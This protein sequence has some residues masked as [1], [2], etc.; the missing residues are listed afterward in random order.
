MHSK[1]GD[2][3]YRFNIHMLKR[4]MFIVCPIIMSGDDYCGQVWVGKGCK[5]CPIDDFREEVEVRD[6]SIAS[7]V[8]TPIHDII[9]ELVTWECKEH[10]VK[11]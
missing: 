3:N 1:L 5:L 7:K 9:R 2:D 4:V 10:G 6:V 8:E 11:S